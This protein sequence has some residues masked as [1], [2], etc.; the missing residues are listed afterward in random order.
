[1]SDLD[2]PATLTASA[3]VVTALGVILIA[4]WSYRGKERASK[5]ADFAEDAT[6]AIVAI[7]DKLYTL[8][9]R[10]DGRLT[11][12]LEQV[13]S[14]GLIAADLARSEGRAQGEQAQRDRASEAQ[15]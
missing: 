6:R 2:I 12:L 7:G 4:Y 14:E 10:V 9:K 8:D 13:R 5:A 15:P 3:A 11:Q 1:M